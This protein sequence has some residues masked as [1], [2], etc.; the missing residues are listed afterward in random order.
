MRFCTSMS[1][2]QFTAQNLTGVGG[3]GKT[4]RQTREPFFGCVGVR[5]RFDMAVIETA[6]V[7]I[8]VK[9]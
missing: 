3:A 8:R 9:V 5:S 1:R 2:R 6:I 4:A 7:L